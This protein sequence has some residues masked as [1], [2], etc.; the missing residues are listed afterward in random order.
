MSTNRL[1]SR[2]WLAIVAAC[3]ATGA[4]SALATKWFLQ[5]AKESVE[6][7]LADYAHPVSTDSKQ[8]PRERCVSCGRLA[9][10]T[11]CCSTASYCS[12]RCKDADLPHK[13]YC[14]QSGQLPLP[15]RKSPRA[16]QFYVSL[17]GKLDSHSQDVLNRNLGGAVPLRQALLKYAVFCTTERL[18]IQ[19]Y[20]V[21]R[22][23]LNSAEE[24]ETLIGRVIVAPH[25][26]LVSFRTRELEDTEHDIEHKQRVLANGKAPFAWT[27]PDTDPCEPLRINLDYFTASGASARRWQVLVGLIH[28]RAHQLIALFHQRASGARRL[29][30]DIP[31]FA[32]LLQ[33]VDE[34]GKCASLPESGLAVEREL[35]QIW[36]TAVFSA[37]EP[38]EIKEWQMNRSQPR[39]RGVPIGKVW[40][41]DFFSDGLLTDTHPNDWVPQVPGMLGWEV[42]TD[43][44]APL[45]QQRPADPRA[46]VPYGLLGTSSIIA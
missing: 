16:Q 23:D 15:L 35:F 20:G 34:D 38:N 24:L 25:I 4:V 33:S 41:D 18:V 29:T 31:P 1:N 30:P 17:L 22:K 39:G 5:R 28:E 3:A 45:P 14:G 7:S 19:A 13:E 46:Q 8:R 12:S 27:R 44:A 43:G 32:G 6:I 40:E 21:L 9:E 36:F 11:D 26:R 37:I 10:L 42:Q 2:G